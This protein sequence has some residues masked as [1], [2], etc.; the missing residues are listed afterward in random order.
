MSKIL[1]VIRSSSERQETESQKQEMIQF[2]IEKGYTEDD[3]K[4]IEVAGASARKLNK[5]YLD[6]LESIKATI[7]NEG[8]TCCAFWHLNRLGRNESKLVEMKDFFKKNKIQVYIK[9]PSIQLFHD[10]GSLDEGGN[11]FWSMMAVCIEKDTDEMFAK[12]KRGKKRNAEQGKYNGSTLLLGFKLNE[13]NYYEVDEDGASVVRLIFDLYA[14]GEYSTA[15][16][17]AE[18]QQRGFKFKKHHIQ[19]ILENT[20]YIGYTDYDDSRRSH[21]KYPRIISDELFNKCKE[22]RTKANT[23][24]VKT[25]QV[26]FGI[27]LL[28]CSECG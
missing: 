16:L 17:A 15:T 21:R 13:N 5:K 1:A 9:Y 26:H 8:F 20:A 19:N 7:I 27:K 3:I 2:C 25:K 18:M 22:I 28:K 14:T 4:V 23:A 11:L 6:M 24:I 12:M 10:D